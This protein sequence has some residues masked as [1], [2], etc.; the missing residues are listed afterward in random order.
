MWCYAIWANIYFIIIISHNRK[1]NSYHNFNNSANSTESWWN[2]IN[3][4]PKWLILDALSSPS[5]SADMQFSLY[6]QHQLLL[7]EMNTL[8]NRK[9]QIINTFLNSIFFTFGIIEIFTYWPFTREKSVMLLGF[10]KYFWT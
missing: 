8:K 9:S 1:N 3:Q 7:P 4:F 10:M 6:L 2:E 5:S